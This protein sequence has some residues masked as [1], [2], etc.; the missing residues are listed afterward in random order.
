MLI[1]IMHEMHTMLGLVNIVLL[2]NTVFLFRLILIKQLI[3]LT[4]ARSR[5]SY[6]TKGRD[7]VYKLLIV[8]YVPMKPCFMIRAFCCYL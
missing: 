5:V 6:I 2:V 4:S 7:K 3:D 1:N 8:V